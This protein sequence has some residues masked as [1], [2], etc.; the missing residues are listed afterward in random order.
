MSG[1]SNIYFC[2]NGDIEK[3]KYYK[4]SIVNTHILNKIS[5]LEIITK[6]IIDHYKLFEYKTFK[7]SQNPN[8]KI[9][10]FDLYPNEEWD[11]SAL[12]KNICFNIDWVKDYPNKK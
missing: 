4:I 9:E 11:Y 5:K 7:L 2:E 6:D 10:W 12:S 3:R 1:M 8:F